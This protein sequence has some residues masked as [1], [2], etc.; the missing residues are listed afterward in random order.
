MRKDAARRADDTR[1]AATEEIGRRLMNRYNR[2]LTDPTVMAEHG[3][4][5][6][7]GFEFCIE[8]NGVVHTVTVTRGLDSLSEG[9]HRATCTTRKYGAS[10]NR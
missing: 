1:A 6:T 3:H 4:S 10:W 5:T 9:D 7:I 8:E 2:G